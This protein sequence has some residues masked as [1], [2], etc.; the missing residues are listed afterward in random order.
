MLF[1]IIALAALVVAVFTGAG[2]PALGEQDLA[3][4]SQ[5]LSLPYTG[6]LAPDSSGS[7]TIGNVG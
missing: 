5:T 4:D 6:G 7:G 3:Y 1:R 2:A